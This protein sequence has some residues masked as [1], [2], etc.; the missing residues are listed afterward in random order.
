MSLLKITL[1][2]LLFFAP[3]FVSLYVHSNIM[4]QCNTLFFYIFPRYISEYFLIDK[5]SVLFSNFLLFVFNCRSMIFIIVTAHTIERIAISI[6]ES[7]CY[8]W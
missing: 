6:T 2:P 5:Y 7:K 8:K 1:Q 4:K 3:T